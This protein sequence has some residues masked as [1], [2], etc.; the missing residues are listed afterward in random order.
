[1]EKFRERRTVCWRKTDSNFQF[2]SIL[3][4]EFVECYFLVGAA[5]T[6]TDAWFLSELLAPCAET[7]WCARGDFLPTGTVRC[8][9]AAARDGNFVAAS[10]RWSAAMPQPNDLSRSL[11]A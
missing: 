1:M 10:N 7:A 9:G 4:G 6:R 8:Y 2:R 3:V 5:G 11:V